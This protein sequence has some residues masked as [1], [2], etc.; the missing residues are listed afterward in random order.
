[1]KPIFRL[2]ASIISNT[3]RCQSEVQIQIRMMADRQ[4]PSF[5]QSP[6]P[7]LGTTYNRPRSLYLTEWAIWSTLAVGRYALWVLDLYQPYFGVLLIFFWSMFDSC[8]LSFQTL[9]TF[10]NNVLFQHREHFLEKAERKSDAKQISH[11]LTILH[12]KEPKEL[13]MG[14][15]Q[16]L[17]EQEAAGKKYLFLAMEKSTPERQEKINEI[18]SKYKDSFVDIRYTIH[19]LRPGEIPG[20]GSNHFEA[21]VAAQKY[22]ANEDEETRNNVIFSKFDCNM[23]LS[24]PLL[25]EIESVWCG[26]DESQRLGVS[27]MPNVFWSA[28]IPDSERSFLEKFISFAMSVSSNMAPFSMSFVSGS[29]N[30]A[31]QAGYT[32]PGLLSEDELTF[33]KKM[34]LLPN[35]RTYRLSSCIMKVFY[36]AKAESLDFGGNIFMPKLERWFIGWIEVH[37][38][39]SQWIFGRIGLPD[40]PPVQYPCKGFGVLFLTFTRLYCAF[41]LPIQTLPMAFVCH[42]VWNL[43]K[44]DPEQYWW[45][46]V[47]LIGNMVMLLINFSLNAISIVRI[48]WRLYHRFDCLKW[49]H[50]TAL[51]QLLGTPLLFWFPLRI[52]Y[53]FFIQGIR[54]RPIVHTAQTDAPKRKVVGKPAMKGGMKV[55]PLTAHEKE[56]LAPLLNSI[57]SENV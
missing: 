28:D 51:I 8:L 16:S 14:L 18:V 29:L 1:L 9:Y 49:S 42:N 45:L 48:Q 4:C 34:L 10:T 22:F 50:S 41:C 31:V 30:G 56:A 47:F 17:A 32:P 27:F 19:E 55:R 6:S 57:V 7:L 40:H 39:L 52:L 21:Q 44:S 3:S 12:Y 11:V 54:N 2:A 23:R 46:R 36:P 25:Q 37:A 13:L 5:S 24:G 33:S 43:W 20:T 26:L 35:A 38:Y 15:V 53:V